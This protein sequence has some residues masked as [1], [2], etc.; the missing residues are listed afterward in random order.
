MRTFF[1]SQKFKGDLLGGSGL[2]SWHRWI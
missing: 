2:L 1:D